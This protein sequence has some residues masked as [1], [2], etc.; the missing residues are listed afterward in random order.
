MVL[1]EAMANNLPMVAFNIPGA[2]SIIENDINGYLTECFDAQEMADKI[3]ELIESKDK[4]IELSNGNNKLIE[5]HTI[6]TIVDL[7]N[8]LIDEV[9]N[10]K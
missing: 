3:V 7:W 6:I 1:L 2:R 4:R 10:D 9:L 8:K 5:K